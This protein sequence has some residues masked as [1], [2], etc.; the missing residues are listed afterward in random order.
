MRSLEIPEYQDSFEKHLPTTTVLADL[1]WPSDRVEQ[2]S[3]GLCIRVPED[4]FYGALPIGEMPRLLPLLEAN[5]ITHVETENLICLPVMENSITYEKGLA[6]RRSEKGLYEIG[7][8]GVDYQS[9]RITGVGVA[10]GYSYRIESNKL[11]RVS[12][13]NDCPCGDV[14]KHFYHLR[15]CAVLDDLMARGK[16]TRSGNIITVTF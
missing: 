13:E 7:G 2:L 5:P 15:A 12:A 8:L 3:D 1:F 4:I 14:R 9:D 11:V 10:R 16:T 6:I